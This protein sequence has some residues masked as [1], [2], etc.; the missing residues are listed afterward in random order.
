MKLFTTASY[1]GS[2]SSAITDLLSEYSTVKALD[3][4]FE[5]RIAYDMF[6]LSELEYYLV[7]NN[8]RHNSSTA[9][10][11][12]LRLCGIYGLNKNIRFENYSTIF[13]NFHKSVIAYINELAP[14]SYKGGSHVDIYMKSDLFIFILKI[15]GLIYNIFHKFESTNDDSAWL[16]KGVTPYERELGKIDYHISYPINVFLE[17]TQRFTEN[18]F[19]SVNMGNN[20]YLMVDQLVPV[21]NTMRFVKY[22]KDLKVICIDRDP[23]D[24]YYNEKKFWKGGIAPSEPKMFVEWYKATRQHK[25]VEKDD[26]NR[27]LRIEF[28]DLIYDYEKMCHNLE[29][30]LGLSSG[31]HVAPKSKLNPSLSIRNIKKW[32]DDNEELPNIEYI[33]KQ[34]LDYYPFKYD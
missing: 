18:L 7:E 15:R 4:D 6:G 33:K 11:M 8:H 34:L 16:L 1:Y 29:S 13:P 30:F 2:G 20:E 23:R 24:V 14:M 12:F 21:S 27:V 32:K 10:N 9:I 22:F 28:E 5:C 31:M 3:S 25:L 19:G 26:K 17:A